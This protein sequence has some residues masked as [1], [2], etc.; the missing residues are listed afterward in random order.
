M[1]GI[2][3]IFDRQGYAIADLNHQIMVMNQ[4][5]AHRGPDDQGCWQHAQQ[6]IGLGH[7][8]LSIIDTSN[9]GHQPMLGESGHV[10]VFNGEIYNHVELR[11]ELRHG[12]HFKTQS[13]TEVI[14]AAYAKYGVD[15]VKKFQGMFAFALWDG[16][17]LFC[18]RD[19]FGIKPFY[20]TEQ[21]QKFYFASESKALLPFLPQISTER[22]AFVEYMTFQYPLGDKT[23]IHSILQLEPAHA[24]VIGRQGKRIWRYWDIHYPLD[25]DHS[26]SYFCD[27]L[28]ALLD[29]S[30]QVHLRA[31]VDI[32]AYVS[33][34]VDSSL[35]GI[36]AA[37]Y[38]PRL[39]LFHGRFLEGSAYDES[40]YAKMVA[41]KTRSSLHIADI[42]PMDFI[43][44]FQDIIY[45]LDF[46]VAGPGSF[47]QY[48]V[49]KMAR[50]QVKVVLGG[51][52][53]DELFG[54]YARYLIA[55]F[56]QTIKAAIDGTADKN[57]P[58]VV[59]P[60]SII[61]NLQML[62]TYKPMLKQFWAQ[63]LFDSL[64]KR[65]YRLIDRAVDMA[66]EVDL[67]KAE[68]DHCFQEFSKIF[69]FPKFE[70][71]ESYFNAMTHFDFKTLLPGLLHVED[72][73]S[74]AH[75]LEA[76]VP[77][78]HWPLVEFLATIPATIKFSSG[79]MKYLL[80][81]T[82][83]HRLPPAIVAR[84][85][86]MGFPVPFNEWMHSHLKEYFL[87]IFSAGAN[88]QQQEISYHKILQDYPHLT[89]FSRKMWGFLSY[90]IWQQQFHDKAGEYRKMLA[91]MKVHSQEL[92][93]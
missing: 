39:P 75:G 76:R 18:A 55:Y 20:Y 33:G 49:S 89:T 5:L 2:A 65:Y 93:F 34:G 1:C 37:E 38:Q 54:G 12:W 86:K 80:T 60:E 68:K 27:R 25:K 67:T 85:D 71:A 63:G 19:H 90:E 70:H 24:M 92:I 61:P 22:Q 74:M 77:F 23:L 15:C 8:R 44:H 83:A 58:Y 87:D 79:R 48:M 91:N 29:E 46:P 36:L 14:L 84:K 35:I 42:G 73:V 11:A 47:P 82:Y 13:D 45:Y 41:Q 81:K 7:R 26:E 10:L 30:M 72:R 59:T 50:K 17:Q 43:Q 78:L 21:N 16:E 88:R 56:E 64:D 32:G 31:D 52:G 66:S 69:N 62:K 9:H 40:G 57:H 28:E 53:G 4:L 51:Q 6:H 3:G